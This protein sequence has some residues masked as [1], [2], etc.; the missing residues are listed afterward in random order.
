M[1]K[2]S[3]VEGGQEAGQRMANAPALPGRLKENLRPPDAGSE[4]VP[5]S[6]E[7]GEEQVLN[8]PVKPALGKDRFPA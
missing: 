6:S 3:G 7:M 4:H 5:D 1:P 2:Q 8:D